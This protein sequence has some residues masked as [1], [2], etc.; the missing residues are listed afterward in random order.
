MRAII[1]SGIIYSSDTSSVD[2][3]NSVL[4]DGYPYSSLSLIVSLRNS[5]SAFNSLQSIHGVIYED[6]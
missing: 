1:K 3:F 6:R 5:L 4:K 2:I